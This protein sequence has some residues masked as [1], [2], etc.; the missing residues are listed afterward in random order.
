MPSHEPTVPTIKPHT[1]KEN[2]DKKGIYL[3]LALL[4]F[5][6]AI[7]L[8]GQFRKMKNTQSQDM[9]HQTASD[10]VNLWLDPDQKSLK[11]DE[12]SSVALM[13]QSSANTKVNSF[14]VY[15]TYDPKILRI[16]ANNIDLGEA[17][18]GWN[19]LYKEVYT[20]G[21]QA[22]LRVNFYT[23]DSPY[24]AGSQVQVLTVPVH[25]VGQGTSSLE[26]SGDL[27]NNTLSTDAPTSVVTVMGVLENALKDTK[28]S[29]ITVK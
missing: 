9:T 12:T 16:D 17:F 4:V 22:Q 5:L 15:L 1:S 8:V 3:V 18:K 14:E 7:L 21:G 29:K 26:F 23:T 27:K 19:K 10:M 11:M 20:R 13:M 6:A 28:G 24:V 25:A 2:T